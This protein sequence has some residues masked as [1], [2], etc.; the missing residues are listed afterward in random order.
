[1]ADGKQLCPVPNP[2][3]A[4]GSGVCGRVGAESFVFWGKIL[5]RQGVPD[6]RGS[7]VHGSRM[8][9]C[10]SR[11]LR[12]VVPAGRGN[13]TLVL[14]AD[15][16]LFCPAVAVSGKGVPEGNRGNQPAIGTEEKECEGNG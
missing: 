6:T 4:N 8:L 3:G 11:D 14:W 15:L 12:G 10:G 16:C 7:L 13:G 1:M 9:Y 2:F 5:Y